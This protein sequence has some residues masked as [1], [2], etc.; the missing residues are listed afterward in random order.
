MEVDEKIMQANV[1]S[2]MS[3]CGDSTFMLGGVL[4]LRLKLWYVC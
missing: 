2:P 3:I 4:G 1:E